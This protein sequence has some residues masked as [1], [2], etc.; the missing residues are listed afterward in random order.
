[1]RILYNN[2]GDKAQYFP[3][4]QVSGYP[5]TNV[6]K[7]TKGLTYRG[8]TTLN[9]L[10]TWETTQTISCLVL[11]FC[12]LSNGSTI[13]IRLYSDTLG[14]VLIYDSGI[15]NTRIVDSYNT[16]T[17]IYTYSTGGG[18][19]R[20]MYIP[21]TSSVIRASIDIYEPLNAYIE[22]S[23][24]LLGTYWQ[25]KIGVE[26]GYTVKYTDTSHTTRIMSNT[27]VSEKHSRLKSISF[28]LPYLT[29][30]DM[31]T[32][33]N[34]IRTAQL[35]TPLFVS[36][37]PLDNDANSEAIYQMYGKISNIPDIVYPTNGH[38]TS[39]LEIEEI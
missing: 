4:S 8:G 32:Y 17:G 10:A 34:I 35:H 1:M 30:S 27:L 25:P 11:P 37:F 38:F 24:I 36:L 7:D 23:R 39:S 3:S 13:R 26:Y 5:I 6:F 18:Y 9:I 20:A 2:I 19:T 21:T 29:G 16:S 31:T 15:Q 12:N 28:T 33:A 22:L 14:S